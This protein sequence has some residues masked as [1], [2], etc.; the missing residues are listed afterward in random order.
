MKTNARQGGKSS[1]RKVY[2]P[3]FYHSFFF[4][5]FF[6]LP[7]RFHEKMSSLR[8]LIL[9]ATS[10][11]LLFTIKYGAIPENLAMEEKTMA[12]TMTEMV[13]LTMSMAGISLKTTMTFQ[14]TQATAP[15]F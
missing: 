14:T 9:E 13:T 3:H 5:V 6:T 12:L 10:D 7:S 11:I 4:S 2:Y 1:E 15:T 8:L